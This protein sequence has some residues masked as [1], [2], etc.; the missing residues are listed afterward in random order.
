MLFN[1]VGRQ[2]RRVGLRHGTHATYEVSVLRGNIEEASSTPL[3]I[4]SELSAV[5]GD[6][7]HNGGKLLVHLSPCYFKKRVYIRTRLI[8]VAIEA[9]FK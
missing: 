2:R 6:G 4:L 7:I 8:T 5:G 3:P 1:T 9:D